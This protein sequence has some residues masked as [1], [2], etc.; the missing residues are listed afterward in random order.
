[1]TFIL[2]RRDA[3]EVGSVNNCGLCH[4]QVIARDHLLAG[5]PGTTAGVG[6]CRRCGDALVNLIQQFGGNLS[7]KIECPVAQAH[8]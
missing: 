1:V 7:V 3:S 2:L 4:E 6:L 5:P 8:G